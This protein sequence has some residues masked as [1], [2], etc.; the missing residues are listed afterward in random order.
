M[1]AQDKEK[2]I[3]FLVS[4]FITYIKRKK[5]ELLNEIVIGGAIHSPILVH[6]FLEECLCQKLIEKDLVKN[7]LN[8]L[9]KLD[10]L[11][12][13]NLLFHY[14]KEAPICAG[15]QEKIFNTICDFEKNSI[16]KLLHSSDEEKASIIAHLSRLNEEKKY[17]E[18]IDFFSEVI[19]KYKAY[20][21]H[22]KGRKFF[23]LNKYEEAVNEFHES[24]SLYR[25]D[26]ICF[27]NLARALAAMGKYSQA[28]EHYENSIKCKNYL[29]P[30]HA[31]KIVRVLNEE[32][33]ICYNK[34]KKSSSS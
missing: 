24:I 7:H 5:V 12:I 9:E 1:I 17:N 21:L 22:S 32:L 33:N 34:V 8:V 2:I 23:A 3:D 6:F 20:I 16:K 26:P 29:N 30:I 18:K 13:P 19:A 11:N 15:E 4:N 27:W 10:R 31:N 14:L 25:N 28:I